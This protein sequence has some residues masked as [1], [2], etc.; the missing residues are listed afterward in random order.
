[1]GPKATAAK[2][3]AKRVTGKTPPEGALLASR[4][5]GFAMDPKESVCANIQ[6]RTC[7][8]VSGMFLPVQTYLK[9]FRAVSS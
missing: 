6:Q 2:A 1:M 3:C 9:Q 8:I 4:G 5:Q 7:T